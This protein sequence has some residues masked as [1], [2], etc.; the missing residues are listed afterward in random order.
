MVTLI[1]IKILS[2]FVGEAWPKQKWSPEGRPVHDHACSMSQGD[3][4]C[5]I[6]PISVPD[7]PAVS[8]CLFFRY[9]VGRNNGIT[10]RG[11]CCQLA[12]TFSGLSRMRGLHGLARPWSG[13]RTSSLFLPYSL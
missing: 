4:T 5:G 8:L 6:V 1:E 7:D 13:E 2:V 3:V 12:L 9:S 11:R 10:S